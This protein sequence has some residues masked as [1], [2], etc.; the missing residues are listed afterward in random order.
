MGSNNGRSVIGKLPLYI[1]LAGG[2]G[3]ILPDF[4]HLYR[5][6]FNPEYSAYYLHH[7]GWMAVAVLGIGSLI[8]FGGRQTANLVLRAGGNLRRLTR[9]PAYTVQATVERG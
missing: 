4:E 2:V 5:L 6:I 9:K 8:A 1:G 7:Y 3:G